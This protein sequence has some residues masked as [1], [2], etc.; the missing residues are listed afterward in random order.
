MS[1]AKNYLPVIIL[2]VVLVAGVAAFYVHKQSTQTASKEAE[3]ENI[4]WNDKTLTANVTEDTASGYHWEITIDNP[5]VIVQTGDSYAA[6]QTADGQ[7]STSGLH[8]YTFD[9]QSQGTAMIVMTQKN[10]QGGFTQSKG[11]TVEVN[12]DGTIA[13]ASDV[14]K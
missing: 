9:G 2:C 5:A 3:R 13:S 8:T 1:K 6:D 10:D 11:I 12:A 14:S 4:S 7:P